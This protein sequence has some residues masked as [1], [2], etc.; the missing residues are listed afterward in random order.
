MKHFESS[1]ES[2][3]MV[4]GLGDY[5]RVG[6]REHVLATFY[7]HLFATFC[8]YLLFTHTSFSIV[9]SS[10]GRWAFGME[11]EIEEM[12]YFLSDFDLYC[13]ILWFFV[14]RTSRGRTVTRHESE[15]LKRNAP[16]TRESRLNHF[17]KK[18]Y[19]SL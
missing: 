7:V 10:A 2:L 4:F 3:R 15:P 19:S 13:L 9:R 1:R 8:F 18:L 17:Q 11:S 12:F 16:K 14:V 6:G 5:F